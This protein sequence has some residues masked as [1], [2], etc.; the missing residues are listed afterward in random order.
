MSLVAVRAKAN[1]RYTCQECGATELIQA[2]HEIPGDDDSLVVLCAECHSKRHPDVPKALFFS[3]KNQ[4]YWRNISASSLAKKLGVHP[5]TVI[6]AAKRLEVLPGK[7]A[8]KD[9][10]QIRRIISLRK[11][12]LRTNFTSSEA[13]KRLGL[14]RFQLNLRIERGVFPQPTFIDST[15]VRYFDESW[16]RIAQLIMDNAP[17]GDKIKNLQPAFEG[18]SGKGRKVKQ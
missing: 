6:R 5:R 18:N 16:V 13:H 14:S 2:H 3:T 12:G 10:K 7:L 8:S 4:P 17:G 15:R 9:E 11:S 1:A